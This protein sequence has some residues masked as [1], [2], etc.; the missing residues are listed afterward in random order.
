[1]LEK[2]SIKNIE[3]AKNQ[4]LSGSLSMQKLVKKAIT[5]GL[6]KVR[7]INESE[8]EFFANMNYP[9]EIV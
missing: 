9:P 2:K 4:F 7:K 6:L 3:L 8:I 1:M 5:E